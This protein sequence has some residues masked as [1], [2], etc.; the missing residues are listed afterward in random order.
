MITIY[1]WFGYELP[2]KERY[3]LIREAGFDSVL[4]LCRKRAFVQKIST[5]HSKFRTTSGLTIRTVKLQ[6]NSIYN[7]SGIVPN[8]KLRQWWCT[9]PTMTNLITRQ[10]LTESRS[11]L[12][13]LNSLTQM[14][15]WKI[16]RTLPICHIEQ[17]LSM[18]LY[19]PCM[20]L[21]HYQPAQDSP[22]SIW[23]SK[24]SGDSFLLTLS[25]SSFSSTSGLETSG[26][27]LKKSRIFIDFPKL[28]RSLVRE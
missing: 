8:L 15:R 17:F 18:N 7:V 5:R 4:L 9:C 16:Y 20:V 1:D 21:K 13:K 12:K 27:Y 6:S 24:L 19:Y 3:R 28:L 10:D 11:L 25:V 26:F 23:F 22:E 2:I 14:L